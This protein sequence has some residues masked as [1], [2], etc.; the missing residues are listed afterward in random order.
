MVN[1]KKYVLILG[2]FDG[3]HIGHRKVIS[4]AVS[5]AKHNGVK[6]AMLTF[7]KSPAEYYN[8]NFEYLYPRNFNYEIIKSLGVDEIYQTEFSELA[9][10][11]AKDYL[12]KIVSDYLPIAIYTGYNYTFGAGRG[13]NSDTLR[14]YS[15]EL[16]YKYFSVE[17]VVMGGESVCSTLIKEKI[18]SGLIEDA[19]IL[20]GKNFSIKSK[21]IEGAKIGRMLGFPTANMNY[22]NGIV[23]LPYGVYKVKTIDRPAIL[24][25]GIKPTLMSK[26]PVLEVH[27]PDFDGDL[28]GQNL[29]IEFLS[30]L[31]D[32]K[33][34]NSVEE[35]KEQIK[36][37][38]KQCLE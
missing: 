6:T 33:A 24:N 13:G 32:E 8:K 37:D 1:N 21:V 3:I 25:W 9:D 7:P 4:E 38:L 34:F 35:L 22:P 2:F 12:K 26:E 14:L 27:I 11:T 31:R 15:N 18:K 5:Y 19:N 29:T 28:Y 16:N 20:L 36:R 30:K 23:R 10:I 17:N